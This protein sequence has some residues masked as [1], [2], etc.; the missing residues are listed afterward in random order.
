MAES[1]RAKSKRRPAYPRNSLRW[2]ARRVERTLETPLSPLSLR[3]DPP[4]P[5]VVRLIQEYG[6]RRVYAA[7]TDLLGKRT[8]S[9]K[10]AAHKRWQ[11]NQR[12][13]Y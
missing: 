4:N 9:E 2:Y 8:K 12:I 5:E 3:N 11:Q 10:Q 6:D 1:A 7:L 13:G